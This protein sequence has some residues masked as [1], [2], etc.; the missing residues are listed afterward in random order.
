MHGIHIVIVAGELASTNASF[1]VPNANS[2]VGWAAK[3]IVAVGGE[4]N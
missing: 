1:H 4:V 2:L 3:E